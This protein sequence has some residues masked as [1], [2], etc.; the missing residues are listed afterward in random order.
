MFM[1]PCLPVLF[2]LY[3]QINIIVIISLTSIL[4]FPAAFFLAWSF[5]FSVLTP[6]AAGS[7]FQGLL[8]AH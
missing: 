7:G 5:F 8:F 2:I 1:L 6:A 3:M 4:C